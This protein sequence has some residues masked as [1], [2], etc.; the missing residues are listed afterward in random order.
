MYATRERRIPSTRVY[1]QYSSITEVVDAIRESFNFF[2]SASETKEHW[3]PES[4]IARAVCRNPLLF[5]TLTSAVARSVDCMDVNAQLRFT[6][7]D[8]PFVKCGCIIG[9]DTE[10]EAKA[11]VTVAVVSTLENLVGSWSKVRFAVSTSIHISAV[12]E[13]QDNWNINL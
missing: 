6:F 11:E 10:V 5:R 3:D 12:C 1:F 7:I 8:W 9:A 13:I 2:S 4:I